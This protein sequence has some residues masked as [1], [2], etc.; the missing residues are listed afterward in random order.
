[1]RRLDVGVLL[2]LVRGVEVDELVVLVLLRR[3]DQ[4]AVLVE[5][6]VLALR[7]LHQG[8]L[9]GAVVES[10]FGEDAV[11]DEELQVVP[12]LLVLLAVLREDGLQ[13]VGH[14]L[15]DVRRDL[16]HLA[17]ALE[18]ASADVQRDVWRVD[19][20]VQQRQELGHDAL[21]LVGHEDLVAVELDLVLLQFDVRLDL[22]EVEDSREVERVVDVQVDPEQRLVAHRVERAV[23]RLVVLVLQC[24]RGFR[25]QRLHIIDDVVL[26][27]VHHLLL[28]AAPFLLLAEGDGHGHELAVLLEQALELVLVEELLAV[29]VDVEDDVG[30]VLGA[31]GVVDLVGRRAVAA[32]LHGLR[33]FLV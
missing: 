23:E 10:L 27:G 26:G 31:L 16:L 25:P 21:H 19:H 14:F 9:L 29:V 33:T 22:R 4:L 8:E 17:V 18:I 11:V 2:L 28:V 20:A 6:E 13:A 24:R 30:A 5:G 12:L 1:M 15:R 7:V 3:L 32:P